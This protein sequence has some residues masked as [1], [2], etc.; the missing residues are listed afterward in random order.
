MDKYKQI[1]SRVVS[2]ITYS[3][4]L[5]FEHYMK[6]GSKLL[7]LPNEAVL[8]FEK[9]KDVKGVYFSGIPNAD[10]FAWSLLFKNG[11]PDSFSRDIAQIA[12]PFFIFAPKNVVSVINKGFIQHGMFVYEYGKNAILRPSSF[13]ELYDNGHFLSIKKVEAIC[14][15]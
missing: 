12:E 5:P 8:L 7:E 10:C 3:T 6:K 1:A 11:T 13:C 9:M 4:N 2:F 15:N 14:C